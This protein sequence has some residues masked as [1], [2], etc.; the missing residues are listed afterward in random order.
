MGV[1]EGVDEDARLQVALLRHH[2][3]EQGVAGDVE[4][5]ADRQIGR[6]LIHLQVEPLVGD[7]ELHQQVARRQGHVGQIG[8]VPGAHDDASGSMARS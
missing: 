4:R 3:E 8:D 5:H 6:A 2:H 1:A 7:V